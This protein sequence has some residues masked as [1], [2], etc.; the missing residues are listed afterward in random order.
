MLLLFGEFE[1]QGREKILTLK[2]QPYGEDTKI[3]ESM[4]EFEKGGL[5][6]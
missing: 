3:E 1:F 2:N 6:S 5:K 4:E